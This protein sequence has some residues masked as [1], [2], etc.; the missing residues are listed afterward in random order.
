MPAGLPE[1]DLDDRL[2]DLFRQL[3]EF[4]DRQ[5]FEILWAIDPLEIHLAP[6]SPCHRRLV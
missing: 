6:L 3:F 4:R 5:S 2:A 1:D